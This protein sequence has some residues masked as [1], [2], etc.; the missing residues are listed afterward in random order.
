MNLRQ[1][2][3]TGFFWAAFSS[4]AIQGIG[5]VSSA[6]LARLLAP[7][8]FGLVDIALLFISFSTI[9]AEFGLGQAIIQSTQDVRAVVNT[10][11][12]LNTALSLLL[13]GLLFLA[14]PTIAAFYRAPEVIWVVRVLALNIWLVG[15]GIVPASLMEKEL[16]FR[17]KTVAE[18]APQIGYTVVAVGLAVA[19]A[20]VWSLVAGLVASNFFRTLLFWQR[21]GFRPYL[22]YDRLVARQLVSFGSHLV[23]ISFLLFG[24]TKLDVAYLG[25]IT[26]PTEVGYYGLAL[27]MTN[28]VVDLVASLF[29]RVT[30]PAFAKLQGN[31]EQIGRAYLRATNFIAYAALP[32]IGG[33][34]AVAPAA[35]LGIYGDRWQP[36]VLLVRILC[37]FAVFR[38]LSRLSGSIFTAT[39]RPDVTTKI[40]LVRLLV[41]AALLFV[42]GSRWQTVGVAWATSLATVL[43]SLWSLWLTNRYLEISH[44]R[45][46]E[47]IW[48]QVAAAV[49]MCV[50]VTMA[51]R[52]L[53]PSIISLV[54]LG[55]L[56]ILLY[57]LFLW[58]FGGRYV[59]RDVTDIVGLFQEWQEGRSRQGD[60]VT[61]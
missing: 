3:F 40:V 13:A 42:L 1:R 6:V 35:V 52:F 8:D 14:A 37:L 11:F 21:A 38:A 15:M 44:R 59:R 54:G 23:L 12:W 41:F 26:N 9:F 25:R 61:R 50:G 53:P 30:F 29:G 16:E 34:F 49:I 43:T 7:A 19:G 10:A 24:T 45:L 55:L 36:A 28:L 60:K 33:I 46:L 58:V 56:G 5:F 17:R 48:P 31:K 2:V 32:A 57:G 39:G 27:T 18:V 51:G 47:T 22:R 20:G 4:F